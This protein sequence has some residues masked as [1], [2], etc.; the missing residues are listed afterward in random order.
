M[1]APGGASFRL[2]RLTQHLVEAALSAQPVAEPPPPRV[3]VVVG[4]GP[5]DGLGGAITARIAREGYSVFALGRTRATLEKTAADINAEGLGQVM[6]IVLEC[7]GPSAGFQP[8]NVDNNKMEQE[9]VDA[10]ARARAAG[11]LDLVVQNQ[12]PNMLPPTGRDMRD[13]TTEFVQYMWSVN[14]LISFIVGREAARCMVPRS[15]EQSTF[16]CGTVVFIGATASMRGKPPFVAFAQGKAGVRFLAQSMAR[17]Y[18][19]KGLHVVHLVVDGM[20]DGSRIRSSGFAD[21]PKLEKSG[22]P[23]GIGVDSTA[24]TVWQL[25]VQDPSAWTHELEVRPFK[26]PW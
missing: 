6:P 14:M 25:S 20:V 19:P 17:E 10:F 7:I 23:W 9:I 12:G 26:E 2:D 11:R 16:P 5:R 18:G 8:A 21:I 13:M 1:D 3:A 15:S 22:G 4:V 24:E